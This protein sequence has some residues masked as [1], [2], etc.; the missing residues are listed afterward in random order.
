MVPFDFY[1]RTRFVFGPD[2]VDE[3]GLLAAELG[4]SR[5]MIVSDPGIVRSGHTEW[6]RAGESRNTRFA[7][8]RAGN[9]P[10]RES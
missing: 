9:Q 6:D 10:L 3:L 8:T 5:A 4:A 7:R 1:P 2:R